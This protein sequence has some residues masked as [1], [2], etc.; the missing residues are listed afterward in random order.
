MCN[1]AKTVVNLLQFTTFQKI[2][3]IRRENK[4]S[5]HN[6]KWRENVSRSDG[7]KLIIQF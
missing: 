5:E 6:W 2:Y 7:G 3:A 4:N 1:T